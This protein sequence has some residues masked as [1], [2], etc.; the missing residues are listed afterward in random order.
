[1]PKELRQGLDA[2]ER[3]HGQVEQ[4]VEHTQRLLPASERARDEFFNRR[5][6]TTSLSAYQADCQPFKSNFWNELIGRFPSAT[7]PANARSRKIYVEEK[8]TGYDVMLDF[9]PYVFA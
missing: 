5:V 7:L 4:L 3:Q 6:N 8:W 1:P 9:W 2:E